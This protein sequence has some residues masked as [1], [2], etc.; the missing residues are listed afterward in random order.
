MDSRNTRQEIYDKIRQSSKDEYVLEEM[1][2]LGFWAKSDATPSL[3][4]EMI[5]KE[6]DLQ[7][8]LNTL[9]QEKQ[10]YNN[11][12]EVLKDMRRKRMEAAKEKRKLTKEKREQEKAKKTAAWLVTREKDIFYLGEGVSEGLN[13]DEGNH[14][15]LRAKGLPVFDSVE[16]LAKATNLSIAEIKFLSFHRKVATTSHYIRFSV[17]KKSGGR[18]VISAPMPK[19]KTL[20]YWILENILNKVPVHAAA[21]GFVTT[22]SIL[23][24]ASHHIGK[25]VVINVDFKD[26]FP[27]INYKRV[28]GIFVKLG[29]SEK[30]A[31]VLA[32]VCTEPEREEATLDGK[33]YFVATNKRTLP[34]GAPTS[35]AITNIICYKLDC[36]FKGMA[37]KLQFSYT[38]YADD[39]S[40]SSD[41]N[42]LTKRIQQLLWRTKKIIADEGFTIHPKKVKVMRKGA[43]QEVTGIV[44]NKK[45][46]INRE[47]LHRFRAL[48]Q[49]IAKNG[50]EG[51][52]WKGGNTID[53]IIGYANFVAQVKPALGNK[54]K[55]Q[56]QTILSQPGIH[57][58]V[59]RTILPSV[60][61]TNPPTNKNSQDKKDGKDWWDVL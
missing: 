23:S 17:P 34:Q 7:R 44:V 20:Q 24:N 37:D 51:K 53:E 56:L 33:K 25:E 54:F 47:T 41:G 10:R 40:F 42:V 45:P 2:R 16:D 39:L 11:R 57:Q 43:R 60:K 14:E 50:I 48:L 30:I 58:R 13:N 35:P 12:E 36:R 6:G 9:I 31:T 38:R 46:G 49:Q 28:K 18:R 8:E 1:K 15:L 59:K 29:Y 27:T 22:K 55:A 26:F 19:L 3:P 32:L 21:N 52:K 61:N 4:E 5:K